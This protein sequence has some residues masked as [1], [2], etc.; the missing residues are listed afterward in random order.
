MNYARRSP[1]ILGLLLGLT[2]GAIGMFVWLHPGTAPHSVGRAGVQ[3]GNTDDQS[4]QKDAHGKRTYGGQ[5]C[6]SLVAMEAGAK[7]GHDHEGES[8][9]VVLSEQAIRENGIE[10][11]VAGPGRLEQTLLLPGEIALNSDK[12]AHVV[13]RVAGIVRQV[14]KTLGDTVKADEVIA[15]LESRELAEAKATCLAA[16]QRRSLAEARFKST[17]EL[18]TKKLKSDL[19]FLTVQKALVE[20]DLEARSAENKLHVLGVSQ[21]KIDTLANQH[22]DL[23][24]YELRAP[25]AGTVIKKHCS[26]GEVLDSQSDVFMIADLNTVWANITVYGRDLAR[27][28]M[29]Q[30]VH[31]RAEGMDVAATGKISFIAPVLN[32]V[33]RTVQARVELPNPSGQWRPGMFITASIVCDVLDV[34]ILVPTEAVQRVENAPVVFVADREGFEPR[35]VTVGRSNTTHTE[36]VSGLQPGRRFVAKGAFILKAELGKRRAVHEH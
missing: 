29:G 35:P 18:Y 17:E 15:I 13:P 26:L 3:G 30:T 8:R 14:F 12:V 11:A 5:R 22:N 25:F 2:L 6:C 28:R 9:C 21:A 19:E 27:I 24:T 7:D 23:A 4:E 33:T 36:I 1:M 16:R 20:A 34:P 31:V 10:V 32:E